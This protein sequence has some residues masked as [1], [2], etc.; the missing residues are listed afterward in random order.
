[1]TVD[2]PS[3]TFT[4]ST[5]TERVCVEKSVYTNCKFDLM[6]QNKN[7]KILKILYLG[8]LHTKGSFVKNFGFSDRNFQC[9][10]SVN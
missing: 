7:L 5:G 10:D 3:G 6:C 2:P 9:Q 8:S 4:V 1:M